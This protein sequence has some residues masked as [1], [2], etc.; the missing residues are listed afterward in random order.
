MNPHVR[1]YL[2]LL[3]FLT[4]VMP[5]ARAQFDSLTGLKAANAKNVEASLLSSVETFKPGEKI[6]LGLKLN[7]APHWHTYWEYAGDAGL[8]TTIAWD[9]PEGFSAEPFLWPAPIVFEV[10]GIVGYGYEGEVVFPLYISAPDEIKPGDSVTLKGKARWLECKELCIPG[11]ADISITL[12]AANESKPSGDADL[13]NKFLAKVPQPLS[14]VSGISV[15]VEWPGVPRKNSDP[16]EIRVTLDGDSLD[17]SRRDAFAFMP[18]PDDNVI[19]DIQPATSI[20]GRRVSFTTKGVVTPFGPDLAN[21]LRGVI[22]VAIANEAEPIFYS[23]STTV[24][25]APNE[26]STTAAPGTDEES[27]AVAASSASFASPLEYLSM[28]L[29]AFIG[30]LILNIMPCVLPVISLKVFAFVK[31]AEESKSRI[32]FLGV[33]YCLGVLASF[34]AMAG[35]MVALKAVSGG[36][37]W[38]ALFQYPIFVI[39]FTAV[40]FVFALN[41]LGVFEISAPSGAA[42]QG[43]A[44]LQRR[45]GPVGAFFTGVLATLLATPCSAPI[46]ATALGFAFTQPP[47]GIFII[48]TGIG[49]GLAFP[50]LLLAAFPAWTKVIPK[51]GPWMIH[52]KQVMGFLLLA[53]A[54]WM[55]F[56]VGR[57]FSS[58]GGGVLAVS[59]TLVFLL[60][61]GFGC[62][63]I[64]A[65]I[66]YSSSLNRKAIV[67]AIALLIAGFTYAKTIHPTLNPAPPN[68]E[69]IQWVDYTPEAL[70]SNLDDN[71]LVFMDFTADWCLTCKSN[72][73]FVLETDDVRKALR[74]A[75]AVTIKVD[76]T[77]QDSA[78]RQMLEGF[79]RSGVPLYV[80]YPPNGGE[81]I[82]LPEIITKQ[83]VIEKL[84][85][86]ASNRSLANL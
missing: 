25:P 37:N 21:E 6:L 48:F 51:P 44:K 41:M 86:A 13:I 82:V 71:K 2:L 70:K 53:T 54:I 45:E 22:R 46:L 59:Y 69:A 4:A 29:F 16:F 84:Q 26:E 60:S 1:K 78:I 7:H 61:L 76:F 31:Q 65:Y 73:K 42:I 81:P 74:Q 40:V 20:S 10:S 24:T 8:P 43:M 80:I 52:F 17:T 19:L 55:L 3:M 63:M 67:W 5:A 34:W 15:S 30:G 56:V 35:A 68:P 58:D 23:Y 32:L 77:R 33:I 47:A 49:A 36:T 18:I 83:I 85:Q 62:W 9:L 75:E 14:D 72:E 79:G 28:L 64:N 11:D 12:T 66:D 39:A 57:L 38:G 27:M 50:F